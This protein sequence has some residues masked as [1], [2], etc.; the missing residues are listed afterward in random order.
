VT[1][2]ERT[3]RLGVL[4]D[5]HLAAPGTPPSQFNNPVYRGQAHQLL[6]DALLWLRPRCDALLLLGDLAD[7]PSARDYRLLLDLLAGTGL[8]AYTVLGNHDIAVPPSPAQACDFAAMTAGQNGQENR[9][10]VPLGSC[11]LADGSIALASSPLEPADGYEFTQTGADRAMAAVR[12]SRLLVWAAHPPVLSLRSA[13]EGRGWSYAGDVRNLDSVAAALSSYDG[14]L[15]AL[16]GH[17]HVRSHAVKSNI[18]QLGQGA[19]AESPYD[20]ALVTISCHDRG[21]DVTRQCHSVADLESGPP[22]ALD[23]A[24]MAFRWDGARWLR[25][26]RPASPERKP[27]GEVAAS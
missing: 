25:A 3:V 2:S 20:A 13:I 4:T 19:L 18:L 16:T 6:A 14:P 24:N 5:L 15:L 21:I 22:A 1:V 7:V 10:P 26:A 17:L 9:A 11:Y 8:P 23:P 27:E 12:P